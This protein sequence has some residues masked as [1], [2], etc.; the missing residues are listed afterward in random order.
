MLPLLVAHLV[1]I[2]HGHFGAALNTA[3]VRL[4]FAQNQFEQG[5]F[6]HAVWPQQADTVTA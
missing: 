1:E 5:G 4:Q 3:T 6:T 2:G